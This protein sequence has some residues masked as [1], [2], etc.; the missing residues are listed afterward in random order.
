MNVINTKPLLL[1]RFRKN[2]DSVGRANETNRFLNWVRLTYAIGDESWQSAPVRAEAERRSKIVDLGKEWTTTPNSKIPTDYIGG[3]HSVRKIFG[4][5]EAIESASADDLMHGLLS[6][7]AFSEQQRFV[8]GGRAAIP[9][10]FWA[11][12]SDI[13]RVKK[14]LEY[15][16]HGP[17]DFIRRLHDVLYDTEM[18]LGGY[19]GYFCALELYG[20]IKPEECPPINGRMAKALRYLGYE[21]RGA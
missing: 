12:N 4:T 8:K 19:F 9:G 3:L 1:A 13:G 15:L 21:V 5:T 6:L 16:I 14:T 20:T 2:P 18:K 7:H 10:A 11:A 17:G